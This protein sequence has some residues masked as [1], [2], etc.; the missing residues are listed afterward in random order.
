MLYAQDVETSVTNNSSFKDEH[1]MP[2]TDTPGLH[3]YLRIP[4]TCR[5]ELGRMQKTIKMRSEKGWAQLCLPE[6][7]A[8]EMQLVSFPKSN[9]TKCEFM[10]A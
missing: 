6:W 5:C 4:Y 2:T 3:H 1:T 7:L 8:L 9:M 10:I